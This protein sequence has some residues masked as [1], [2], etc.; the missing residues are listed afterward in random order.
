MI[1]TETIWNL[2]GISM[3]W[4]RDQKYSFEGSGKYLMLV[5]DRA[6]RDIDLKEKQTI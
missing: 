3:K 6:V 1:W 2:D 4:K 5:W